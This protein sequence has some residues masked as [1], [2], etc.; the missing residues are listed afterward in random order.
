MGL[1]SVER[2]AVVVETRHSAA[3]AR[4]PTAPMSDRV[5]SAMVSVAM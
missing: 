3:A 1:I 2:G 5:A 4:R